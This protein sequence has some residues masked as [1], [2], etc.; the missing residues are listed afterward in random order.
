MNLLRYKTPLNLG[1]RNFDFIKF[2]DKSA[3]YILFIIR[4]N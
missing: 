2:Q 4:V 1:K 3:L